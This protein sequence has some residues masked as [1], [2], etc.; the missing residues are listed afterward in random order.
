M[1]EPGQAGR[2]GH[3]Q[4]GA[5]DY[6]AARPVYP[7][8]LS[9]ALAEVAPGRGLAVDV[10]CGSGQLTLALAEQFEAVVGVDVSP[11]QLAEAPAHPRIRWLESGAE[12]LPAADG[13]A[14]LVVVAQA[15]HW[16]DLPLFYAEASRALRPGGVI[17]LVTYGPAQVSGPLSARFARFY[18]TEI[19]PFWPPE[20]VHVENG[21]RDLPF[22]FPRIPMPPLAISAE[23]PLA[24]LLAYVRSWSAARAPGA[25]AVV[26]AFHDDAR[27]MLAPDAP[28]AI[29]F[30]LTVIAGTAPR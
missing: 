4:S 22:P 19:A 13:A 25:D 5:D 9:A 11:A 12:A 26:A 28:V 10:G 1:S 8:E 20:R 7:P 18:A 16:F 23:W 30:P 21:Y 29:S 6:A 14:D 17:A 3:F 15:A 27:A 2:A 24:R